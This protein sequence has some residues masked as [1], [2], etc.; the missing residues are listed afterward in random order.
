M[1][2]A[3]FTAAFVALGLA[4][5]SA[6][7]WQAPAPAADSGAVD[8][9]IDRIAAIPDVDSVEIS[10]DGQTII[11]AVRA[12]DLAANAVRVTWRLHSMASGEAVDL[13]ADTRSVL[14]LPSSR[15]F[16]AL[17]G[18]GNAPVLRRVGVEGARL[19][20]ARDYAVPRQPM[21]WL[22]VS[23]RGDRIAFVSAREPAAGD[24]ALAWPQDYHSWQRGRQPLWG[25]HLL[26]LASGEVRSV[27]ARDVNLSPTSSISWSPD[28]R[29]IAAAVDNRPNSQNRDTDLILFD[30]ATGAVRTLTDLPGMDANPSWSP[31]GR[32]IAF[33]S[34]GGAP[35]YLSGSPA[36]LDLASNRVTRI[37]DEAGPRSWMAAIWRP[38]SRGFYYVAPVAMKFALMR[39]RSTGAAFD[40]CPAAAGDD[41]FV[42]ARSFSADRRRVAMVAS[43]PLQPPQVY[44]AELDEQ[45]CPSGAP[46]AIWTQEPGID[47]ARQLRFEEASWRSGDGRFRIHGTLLIPNGVEGP[48]PGLLYLE[49]G[50]NM[51]T[52]NFSYYG[53][54]RMRLVLALRGFAV[55]TPNTRGRAGYGAAF[56]DAAREGGN[57][58]L[59]FQDAVLGLDQLIARGIV[60]PRRQAVAGFSYGGLLTAHAVAASRRRFRAAIVNEGSADL[61][62]FSY[63]EEPGTYQLLMARDL[64]GFTDPF[65]P[66]QWR[67]IMDQSP[68][69]N[70]AGADTPTLLIYGARSLA[71]EDGRRL[72]LSMRHH[73]VPVRFLVY[74]EGHTLMTP[75]AVRSGVRE[76]VR[77]IEDHVSRER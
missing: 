47:F 4:S 63:P 36:L 21:Q 38:D 24:P 13:P 66:E 20:P 25:L 40:P 22:T 51:V 58:V 48:R 54:D 55:L 9:L 7:A 15:E 71:G 17:A 46:R 3:G 53:W 16:L 27:G 68:G 50:P 32:S 70:M 56:H 72:W 42:S 18:P 10:P 26:D 67:R 34:H 1:S 49:G 76:S 19:T 23:N 2:R 6:S 45:G 60:D 44:V 29:T 61:M 59:P 57:V 52:A 33:H 31:D 75:A 73:Q 37:A 39:L 30:L 64:G 35:V 8:A 28:D 43:T 74:D 69:L 14:W 77:W 5:T 62:R 41:W 65:R 11:Y 12:N